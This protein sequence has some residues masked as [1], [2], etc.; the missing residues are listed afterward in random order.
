MNSVLN[1]VRVTTKIPIAPDRKCRHHK[2]TASSFET[3]GE[4]EGVHK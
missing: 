4:G 3:V 2:E 1:V